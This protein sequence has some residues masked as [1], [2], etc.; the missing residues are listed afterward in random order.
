MNARILVGDCRETLKSLPDGSVQCCV[1][2]P[3]YYGLRDY[4]HDGQLGLEPTP[5]EYV[6]NLV[7]VFREVRR[8]LR[9]DGT[10]W[11]NLG[12]SYGGAAGNTRG[13][14]AGGGK[15]RG[16][17][18]FRSAIGRDK[19]GRPKDLLGIPWRVAFA[20][21]ADGWWLRSDIVWAKPNPMPE[22]VTD[23]PTKAHEYVFLLSKSQTYYYDADAIAEGIADS[24][25]RI[26]SN[27]NVQPRAAALGG[28][29]SDRGGHSG[30]TNGPSH[31]GDGTRNARTVWTITTQPYK[32]NHFAV[33]P[34]E[35][36]RR[37]IVAGTS[38]K[39]C[40]PECGAPWE[41]VVE[42]PDQIRRTAAIGAF[43]RRDRDRPNGADLANRA[44]AVT[45]GWRPTCDHEA[46]PVP[47]VVLDP[48]AGSG[49]V[50]A[51]A[52]GNGRAAV[53]CE[54][55]AE[56]TD[57]ARRRIGPMFVTVDP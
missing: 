53:L 7:A 3:P 18:M 14:G 17:K 6:A 27:P 33:F 50:G 43:E 29:K 19:G 15:E 56:Y 49:T 13:D 51:V 4:G 46:E 8:V 31:I 47:C 30:L 57:M 44:P 5:D 42:R 23:R 34:E 16:E 20:L 12:D 45:T 11:L 21:Q 24:T 2:S 55:N 32:E 54:L 9:D 22:S 10:V 38:Q 41:R 25:R 36:A 52:V 39:G 48:F 40:C 37:C 35:L 26:H 28:W 1:T